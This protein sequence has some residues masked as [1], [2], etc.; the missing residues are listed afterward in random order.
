M[1]CR[2]SLVD[3]PA[4]H[5]VSCPCLPQRRQIAA[6]AACLTIGNGPTG[7]NSRAQRKSTFCCCRF[8]AS[9]VSDW[10]GVRVLWGVSF[11]VLPQSTPPPPGCHIGFVSS[12][13][14]GTRTRGPWSCLSSPPSCVPG[15]GVRV[16]PGAEGHGPVSQR[17]LDGQQPWREEDQRS[18]CT[19]TSCGLSGVRRGGVLVNA[20]G[21]RRVW[22]LKT[23]KL[24][25]T[26]RKQSTCWLAAT[27]LPFILPVCPTF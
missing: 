25:V 9:S 17:G 24:K 10:T 7:S 8:L 26:A 21:F 22:N 3:R 13:R 20:L 12:S 6:A 14:L 16:R 15:L 1:A 27:R 11:H 4:Q 5:S 18:V 19:L 2:C 23:R